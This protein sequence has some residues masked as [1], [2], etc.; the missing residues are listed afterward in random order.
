MVKVAKLGPS[1]RL[2]VLQ[3]LMKS[4]Q[5]PA[6]IPSKRA[7]VAPPLP[8]VSGIEVLKSTPGVYLLDLLDGI[9]PIT[10]D[11]PYEL[12]DAWKK[13]HESKWDMSFV[14][15]VFCHKKHLKP[16]ELFPDFVI[17]R[18]ELIESLVNLADN[19]LWAT[20]GH[21]NPYFD[22]GELCVVDKVLMFGCAGRVPTVDQAGYTIKV[23]RD[24]RDKDGQGIGPKVPMRD[25]APHVKVIGNKVALVAPKPIPVSVSVDASLPE[26]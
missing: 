3:F 18:D 16:D 1:V 9:C 13:S 20:Q 7:S 24:G 15:F 26:K 19:N 8:P 21:L 10:E 14:R 23:F 2:V 4:A 6:I 25:K 17:K 5:V 22:K 11:G 12:V